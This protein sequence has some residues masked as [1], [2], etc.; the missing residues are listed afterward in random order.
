LAFTKQEKKDLVAGYEKRLKESKASF[1][2]AYHKMSVKDIEV[3][4]AEARKLVGELHVLKN[5]L[6]KI[7][8]E[9]IGFKNEGIFDEASIVAFAYEDAPPIAKIV[10][11]ASKTESFRIKG[12]FMDG[13]PIE[14]DQIVALAALPPMPQMRATLLALIQTPATQFVRT[15]AEPARQVA[16][17]IKAYSEKD[18]AP[19]A[20]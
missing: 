3:F 8:L 12:G 19:A 5:T 11:T 7:A 18:P 15:I 17:V 20:G 16:A 9:N 10:E 14:T 13:E 6:V 4:R 1:V 2:M